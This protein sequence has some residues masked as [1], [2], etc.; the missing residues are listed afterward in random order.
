MFPASVFF[1]STFYEPSSDHFEIS[2]QERILMLL[3]IESSFDYWKSENFTR[4]EVKMK[5]ISSG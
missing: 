2:R 5:N 4:V 3:E 1:L